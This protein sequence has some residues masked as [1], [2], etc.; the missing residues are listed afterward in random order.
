M[1]ELGDEQGTPAQWAFFRQLHT[2]ISNESSNGSNSIEWLPD[3]TAFVVVHKNKVRN[4]ILHIINVTFIV[5]STVTLPMLT[6]LTDTIPYTSVFLIHLPTDLS[7]YS[8]LTRSYPYTLA[9]PSLPLSP[10][11]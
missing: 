11:G 3:G 4:Y 7:F 1:A 8:S 10:G 9:K 5:I 6:L 2:M